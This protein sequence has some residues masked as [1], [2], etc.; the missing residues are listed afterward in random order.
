MDLI[1]C[2]KEAPYLYFLKDTDLLTVTSNSN[3]DLKAIYIIL[4]LPLNAFDQRYIEFCKAPLSQN[5]HTFSIVPSV[6]LFIV[7]GCLYRNTWF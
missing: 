4:N 1:D 7:R 2:L 3:S 5:F 6:I